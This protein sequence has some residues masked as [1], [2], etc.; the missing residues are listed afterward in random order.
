MLQFREPKPNAIVIAACKFILPFWLKTRE[1]LS[2]SIWGKKEDLLAFSKNRRA[3]V[4]LNHPDRQDPFVVFQLAIK[5]RE[6]FYCVAAR[7]CFDWDGGWRGWLFQ[8]LGC[9]SVTRGQAD[10]H[11][12]ATSKKILSEGQHKLLVFPEGEI[13][14]D[15]RKLHD[16]HN[17]IFHIALSVQK[18]LAEGDAKEKE[19]PVLIIPAAIKVSLDGEL[20]PAIT[21]ALQ[22]LEKRLAIESNSNQNVLARVQGVVDSYLRLLFDTYGIEKPETSREKIP[23]LAAIKILDRIASREKISIDDSLTP[24]ERLYSMRNEVDDGNKLSSVALH[25]QTFFCAGIPKPCLSSDFERMERLLILQRMLEHSSSAI[26]CCRILDFIECELFDK[27][28]PKGWQSCKLLLGSAIEASKYLEHY[29]DSKEE[30]V[31]N[32]SQEFR[33]QLQEMLSSPEETN[34]VQLN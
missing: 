8:S 14:A 23:E 6:K 3:L 11:S 16:F 13:T 12:I 32:L 31:S 10:F 7:E 34:L 29:E 9:Y 30:A 33:Q 20:E 1:H 2:I 26:Q 22:K 21:P 4:L 5:M 19:H 18:E 27:I 15:E 24:T 17:A 28:S 25:P